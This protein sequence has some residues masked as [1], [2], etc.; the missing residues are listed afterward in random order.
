M[1]KR[2]R[3]RKCEPFYHR[4]YLFVL[5]KWAF[6]AFRDFS[7]LQGL[8]VCS[9]CCRASVWDNSCSKTMILFIYVTAHKNGVGNMLVQFSFREMTNYKVT[10]KAQDKFQSAINMQGDTTILVLVENLAPQLYLTPLF[11]PRY[12]N[13]SNHWSHVIRSLNKSPR[14]KIQ[15]V[16]L[17]APR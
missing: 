16:V 9:D 17:E 1:L 2:K 11:I 7:L 12:W 14:R 10:S 5:S 4:S 13:T 15:V 3:N 8:S 6:F